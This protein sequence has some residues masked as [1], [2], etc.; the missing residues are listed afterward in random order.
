MEIDMNFKKST[1]VIAAKKGGIGK[2][3]TASTLTQYL[4]SIG[5]NVD[6]VDG[7]PQSPKLSLI[8][9]L[10]APLLPLIEHG[11]I[12]QSAFDPAFSHIIH[13]DNATLIDTGSGAFL[14]LLKYMRDNNLYELLKQVNK[15]L[16]FHVIVVS[17]P[18]KNNTA[19]GAA[20]LLEKTKGTGT[21]VVIWQNERNGIPTFY[22]KGIDE[23]DWYQNNLDQIAGIVKIRDYNNSA[24]EADF[25]AMM[26]E[27]LIYQEIMNGK[28]N[29]FDFMRQNRINR[30][31]TDVYAELDAI[32][33]PL[34]N[35]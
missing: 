30:I 12:K 32:F 10:N 28:S 15:Q 31:F 33:M 18:E 20:E 24:F 19:E 4:R 22:G 1:H 23:T 2:T 11:E 14:P 27:N 6:A 25:L 35:S 3:L 8:K 26:E 7:D 16:Y 9:E 13:T 29:T 34:L 17:G 5:I 21:K